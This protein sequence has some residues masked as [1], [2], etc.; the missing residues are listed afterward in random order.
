[1]QTE[2]ALPPA[3]REISRFPCKKRRHMPGSLTTPGCP[4]TRVGVL[5]HIAFRYLYSVG[6]QD[7]PIAAQWL[8]CAL[9]CRRFTA[10][11]AA[12][13][14]R[15][16]CGSLLLHRVGLSPTTSRQSPGAQRF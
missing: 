10:G 13:T 9:P 6:T 15:G 3:E 1:M 12:S 11:L 8:A 2:T 7:I 14:A 4:S 5:D 16:R